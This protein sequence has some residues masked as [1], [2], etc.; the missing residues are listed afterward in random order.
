[1]TAPRP[2]IAWLM[3]VVVIV[4]FELAALRAWFVNSLG[5]RTG[6]M[7]ELLVIGGLP[8]LSLLVLGGLG[9]R[10]RGRRGFLFGFEVCGVAALTVYVGLTLMFPETLVGPCAVWPLDFLVGA[11]PPTGQPL[12][13]YAQRVAIAAVWLTLPQVVLAIVGGLLFRR[14]APVAAPHRG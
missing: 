5:G 12:T 10:R 7:V 2:S 13:W 4:A 14:F 3:T 9:L 8:M 6:A 1:M 11:N